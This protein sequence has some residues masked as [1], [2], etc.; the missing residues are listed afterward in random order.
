MQESNSRM[1]LSRS[2]EVALH[3]R[4]WEAFHQRHSPATLLLQPSPLPSP[5][6]F[7]PFL[8]CLSLSLSLVRSLSPLS[9]FRFSPRSR[10]CLFASLLSSFLAFSLHVV[11]LLLCENRRY[12]RF[13]FLSCRSLFISTTTCEARIF[14]RLCSAG[15][16][17]GIGRVSF[18]RGA[19]DRVRRDDFVVWRRFRRHFENEH[20]VSCG[21]GQ[22]CATFLPLTIINDAVS[23]EF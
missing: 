22:A 6:P 13:R 12:V 11:I 17:A 18:K 8:L 2:A 16:V 14:P 3:V 9:L 15:V 20:R 5:S 4:R 10:P 1:C 7:V 23:I 21:A 19:V